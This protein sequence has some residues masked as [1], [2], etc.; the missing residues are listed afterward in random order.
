[1]GHM[2][3][4]L[5]AGFIALLALSACGG[6][7]VPIS[8][9]NSTSTSTGSSGPQ[10]P[11]I[12]GTPATSVVAGSAYSFTPTVTNPSGGTLVFNVQNNPSWA[13][14]NTQSGQISGTP[15]S[16]AIGSYPNIVISVSAG[17]STA[18]LPAFGITVS[19]ASLSQ[20]PTISGTPA[21]SIAAGSS[22][23]FTPT[24][25]NPIGG[26]LV[27]SI[28]GQPSW[29]TF[30]KQTGQISGSPATTDIGSYPN[31]IISVSDGTSS[32][33][34][35]AFGITVTAASS[36]LSSC[37]S[38][39]GSLQLSAKVARATG[40]SPLMVFFD[41]TA[42]S[43]SA[44]KTSV[45][46]DVAF[47]WSFG[48]TG[49]SGSGKWAYGSNASGNSMNVGSG[50]VA[51]HLYRTSG[52]DT[53]YTATVTATDGTNTTS[54][55]IGVTAY[56]AG[57]SNGF[58]G[59]ATTCVSSSGTPVAGSGGCPSGA[60]VLR[61]SSVQSALSSAYGNGK[62]VLFKCGDTFSGDNGGNDNLTA[63]KWAIGAYGGAKTLR[64]IDRYSRTAARTT[65]LS[66]LGPT[67]TARCLTSIA[68]G[69][70]H[71]AAAAFGRMGRPG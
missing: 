57:G 29:A 64:A 21:T 36:Q 37:A 61:T 18:T 12:S 38:Q 66:S 52:S 48:D 51:A 63:V 40:I 67:A 70:V 32:A 8:S 69:T 26:T 20:G 1:M 56:D 35:P 22:Y 62:R 31:I 50:I 58:P 14:F 10:V 13:S 33:A 6:G 65:S 59:A 28:Q 41:A 45:T 25:T 53:N 4:R 60:N 46:Q 9:G 27:F 15:A 11:T 2:F 23:S 34:L 39:S 3:A 55:N 19:A 5:L 30:S 54:C 16:T 42:T 43:D 49:A 71:R 24:V 44:V 7:S 47:K 17:A 68:K